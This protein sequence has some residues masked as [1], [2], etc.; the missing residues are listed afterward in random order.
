MVVFFNWNVVV[1]R[2]IWHR[3]LAIFPL[4]KNIY[5]L[6]KR[7]SNANTN[8]GNLYHVFVEY[9]IYPNVN[10]EAYISCRLYNPYILMRQNCCEFPKM[11]KYLLAIFLGVYCF[12]KNMFYLWRA[13]IKCWILLP[14]ILESMRLWYIHV[15]IS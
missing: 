13:N 11:L 2:I 4:P 5:N 7:H 1:I 9:I 8:V 12:V 3:I 14:D 6:N 10:G 15:I